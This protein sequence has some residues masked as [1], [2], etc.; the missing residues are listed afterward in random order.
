MKH[1]VIKVSPLELCIAAARCDGKTF[2]R[3][4]HLAENTP[5]TTVLQHCHPDLLVEY[6][7]STDRTDITIAMRELDDF[8]A[9]HIIWGDTEYSDNFKARGDLYTLGLIKP[10]GGIDKAWTNPLPVA[11]SLLEYVLQALG[12]KPTPVRVSVLQHSP[13]TL[14]TLPGYEFYRTE[15]WGFTDI[16]VNDT[17]EVTFCRDFNVIEQMAIA[18]AFKRQVEQFDMSEDGKKA[19]LRLS[20]YDIL[21]QR[22]PSAKIVTYDNND[23]G[24]YDYLMDRSDEQLIFVP[25]TPGVVPKIIVT[26]V[27]PLVWKTVWGDP[28]LYPEIERRLNRGSIRIYVEPDFA[29]A[30]PTLPERY[31]FTKDKLSA[32]VILNNDLTNLEPDL[33]ALICD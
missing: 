4:I 31:G 29:I 24:V 2:Q 16:T 25:V 13:G 20:Y 18:G 22:N 33:Y 17:G 28:S 27:K 23:L 7:N 10:V 8:T 5:A 9:D 14:P 11:V 15:P 1:C 3:F 6:V 30:I 32:D 12:V 26:S 19:S 21:R